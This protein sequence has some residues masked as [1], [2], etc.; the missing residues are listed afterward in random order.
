[1]HTQLLHRTG[2]EGVAGSDEHA[3][4]ILQK[5]E[6]YLGEV[7]GLAHAID[8][9]K[10][11]RVRV[12]LAGQLLVLGTRGEG[13]RR[14]GRRSLSLCRNLEQDVRAGLGREDASDGLF[15]RLLHL[16]LDRAEAAE[17]LSDEVALHAVA[18]ALGDIGGNIFALEMRGHGRECGRESPLW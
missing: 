14:G 16:G 9:D 12:G 1:M 2:S 17:V 18:E 15:E 7:G 13:E 11:D 3:H 4:A 10:A 6:A 5:P 8:A